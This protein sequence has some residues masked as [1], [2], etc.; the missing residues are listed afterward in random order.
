MDSL[1]GLM[2]KS[3]NAMRGLPS[4]FGLNTQSETRFITLLS[5]V[6]PLQ[7]AECIFLGIHA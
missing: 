5:L 2:I 3:L 1:V 7:D 4:I 6:F